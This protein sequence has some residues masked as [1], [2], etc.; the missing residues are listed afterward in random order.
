MT[1]DGKVTTSCKSSREVRMALL[2]TGT[3][4]HMMFIVVPPDR[5]PGLV[6][7]FETL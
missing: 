4:V 7:L 1:E 6:S 2:P 3:S 5:D